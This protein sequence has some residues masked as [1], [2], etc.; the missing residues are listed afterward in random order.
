MVNK[1]V[2]ASLTA[3]SIIPSCKEIFTSLDYTQ[4]FVFT[5]E[6]IKEQIEVVKGVNE[7]KERIELKK[8]VINE[9]ESYQKTIKIEKLKKNI[10]KRK[11][12]N[13]E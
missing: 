10:I 13:I 3:F 8:D 12:H 6:E 7:E 4:K 11:K 9:P 5:E 1:L 2:I